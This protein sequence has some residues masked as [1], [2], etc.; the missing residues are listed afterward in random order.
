M[1]GTVDVETTL[2]FEHVRAADEGETALPEPSDEPRPSVQS[3]EFYR[4]GFGIRT[5]FSS[6]VNLVYLLEKSSPTPQQKELID[7]LKT[8]VDDLSII[9]VHVIQTVALSFYFRWIFFIRIP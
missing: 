2:E 3:G 5:P 4:F 6:I 7:G 8:S 9:K 1:A